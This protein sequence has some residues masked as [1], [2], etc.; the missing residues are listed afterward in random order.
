MSPPDGRGSSVKAVAP[1]ARIVRDYGDVV[2][3]WG[4]VAQLLVPWFWMATIVA[5]AAVP[6]LVV[7]AVVAGLV[8]G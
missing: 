5:L 4:T 8:A 7:A 2:G 6:V 3:S 1:S